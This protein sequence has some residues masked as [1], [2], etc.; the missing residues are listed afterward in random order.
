L[1]SP[2]KNNDDWSINEW[3]DFGFGSSKTSL[4]MTEHLKT[5]EGEDRIIVRFAE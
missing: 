2:N 4:V 5:I 3:V 1:I